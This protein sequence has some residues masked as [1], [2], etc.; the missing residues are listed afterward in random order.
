MSTKL[1]M[2]GYWNVVT[3][4][5]GFMTAQSEFAACAIYSDAQLHVIASTVE[6]VVYSFQAQKTMVAAL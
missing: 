5:H 3:P 2:L 6:Y 1:V 4:F